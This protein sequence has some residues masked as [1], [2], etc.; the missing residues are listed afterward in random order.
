VPAFPHFLELVGVA[1]GAHC[2]LDIGAVDGLAVQRTLALAIGRVELGGDF[3]QFGCG[4][5]G[6]RG[7]Q[8]DAAA[9]LVQLAPGNRVES[10]DIVE[11]GCIDRRL[12]RHGRA[13]CAGLGRERVGIMGDIGR[14]DPVGAG[15]I[16]REIIQLF[17]CFLDE[18]ASVGGR[19]W[20]GFRHRIL[21]MLLGE[22]RRGNGHGGDRDDRSSGFHF[23]ILIIVILVRI[24][25]LSR[26]GQVRVSRQRQIRA[27]IIATVPTIQAIILTGWARAAVAANMSLP[28]SRNSWTS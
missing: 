14:V 5:L 27:T 19:G 11:P 10:L 13:L 24:E 23:V 20:G 1:V 8:H 26:A 28:C 18:L 15:C 7:G 9:Q 25:T 4:A 3:V 17:F 22:G 6:G 2:S 12:Y 21:C 16:D